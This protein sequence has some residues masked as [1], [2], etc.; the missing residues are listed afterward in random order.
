MRLTTITILSLTAALA[1]CSSKTTTGE[2]GCGSNAACEAGFVC[3]DEECRQLCNSDSDCDETGFIC[4]GNVCIVGGRE[5]APVITG[6]D[7]DGTINDE[8]SHTDHHI[9]KHL[10]IVGEYLQGADA[11]LSDSNN[12]WQ[13]DV[14]ESLP[15][16]LTV[17]LPELLQGSYTLTVATQAGTCS[18]TLPVLRGEQGTAGTDGGQGAQ[19]PQGAQGEAG[20]GL[21]LSLELNEAG[22]TAPVDSSPFDHS[23]TAGVSGLAQG[24]LGHTGTAVSF[25]GGVITVEAPN[26]LGYTPHV[27]IE[28]WI[29]PQSPMD[30]VRTIV[31]KSGAYALKQ[32][33]QDLAFTVTGV[34]S[35]N[36]CTATSTG[37]I[38]AVGVW[39]HVAGWYDGVNVT[40]AVNGALR[41]V[42]ACT[43]GVVDA[44]GADQLFVGALNASAAEPYVGS[45]DEVRVRHTAPAAAGLLFPAAFPGSTIMDTAQQA[46]LA[47]WVGEPFRSW[48]L[49]YRKSRD[50]ASHATFHTNCDYRGPTITVIDIANGKIAGGYTEIAWSARQDYQGYDHR[51]FLFS[52]TAG[53]KYPVG[54][55]YGNT[56]YSHTGSRGPT[57]GNGHDLC[58]NSAMDIEYCNFPFA[59]SC[60]GGSITPN[61]A[62]T[63]ELC[64]TDPG[65][66]NSAAVDE[67]EVWI[68]D[69]M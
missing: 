6:V 12:T 13:L 57:F 47:R 8:P 22:G 14:C 46:Q 49:C 20:G 4:D 2:G 50:G 19:G 67:L 3:V 69:D 62:C 27:W 32:D 65:G 48:K 37:A 43:A 15:D 63:Q 64:G 68:H 56:T 58:V 59:Y 29:H 54:Y 42:A 7:G 23:V 35:G 5:H 39:T 34:G 10:I 16:R 11:T 36:A 52:L 61:T 18:S 53:K 31:S 9:D 45:I 41:A 66:G 51:G 24:S 28:A 25:S 44:D 26:K 1:G 38:L 33:H 60:N 30:T 21:M 17:A 55:Y 40:V